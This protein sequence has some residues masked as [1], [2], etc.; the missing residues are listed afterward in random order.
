M[1]KKLK[2]DKKIVEAKESIFVFSE[3]KYKHK[4]GLMVVWEIWRYINDLE[5]KHNLAAQILLFLWKTRLSIIGEFQIR[6]QI[7]IWTETSSETTHWK[8]FEAHQFHWQ[9][10]IENEYTCTFAYW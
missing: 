8:H 6:C 5:E 4:Y 7:K 10:N 9:I 2:K 1:N 3:S